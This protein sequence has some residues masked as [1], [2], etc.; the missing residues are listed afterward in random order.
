MG[1]A[2]VDEL[3]ATKCGRNFSKAIL[4]T[5]T[6]G[7]DTLW[8]PLSGSIPIDTPCSLF[9]VCFSLNVYFN[10]FYF[11]ICWSYWQTAF[12]FFAGRLTLYKEGGKGLFSCIVFS[13][14]ISCVFV[15]WGFISRFLVFGS[16]CVSHV[17]LYLFFVFRVG[18]INFSCLSRIWL[19]SKPGLNSKLVRRLFK[20]MC[21]QNI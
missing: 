11:N 17:L 21:S 10:C 9:F 1:E 5:G 15:F 8:V 6:C 7:Q 2:T 19:K 14:F 12:E 4:D 20:I 16:T 18:T 13:L 3:L